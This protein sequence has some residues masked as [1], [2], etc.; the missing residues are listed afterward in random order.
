MS[1][2]IVK[3]SRMRAEIQK[4]TTVDECLEMDNKIEAC[5]VYAA[6]EKVSSEERNILAEAAI[7]NARKGGALLAKMERRDKRDNLKQAPKSHAATSTPTLNDIGI[8]RSQSSRWQQIA[9]VPE[10]KL[11]GHV[12]AVKADGGELTFAGVRRFTK[13]SERKEKETIKTAKA[14]EQAEATRQKGKRKPLYS[15]IADDLANYAEHFEKGSVDFIITDPPYPKK[16]LPLYSTLADL[17]QYVLVP[18]GSLV[19]MVGQSY[20]PEVFNHLICEHAG[21]NYQWTLAYLTPGGQSVQLWDRKVNTFWKPLLWFTNGEYKREWHGDVCKS[22]PNDNDK[23][24]HGWGQSE[25][26]MRDIVERFT[27]PGDM[28]L[29]PFCGAGTTGVVAVSLLREFV[30]MDVDAKCIKTS[31]ERLLCA[32]GDIDENG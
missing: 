14:K 10:K 32:M 19:C 28:I 27:M 23:R 5:R 24:F 25:S 12:E 3:Y 9:K 29:D 17:A 7:Y 21:L 26:G 30:G 1:D 8:S 15:L 22:E 16:Y 18:G 6:K 11:K 2:A 4:F 31:E 20:L 13:D